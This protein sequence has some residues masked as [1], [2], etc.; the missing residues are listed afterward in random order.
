[1]CTLSLAGSRAAGRVLYRGAAATATA[2]ATASSST[3]A[4]WPSRAPGMSATA[5]NR[6]AKGFFL[7]RWSI[8]VVILWRSCQVQ[9]RGAA[10][11]D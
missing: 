8:V 2:P 4:A 3:R 11:H 7:S 9:R 1:M 10:A 6:F 5:L